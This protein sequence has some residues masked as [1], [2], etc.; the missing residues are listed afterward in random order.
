LRKSNLVAN[1][2]I[3]K[4]HVI[5]CQAIYYITKVKDGVLALPEQ[6]AEGVWGTKS[7]PFLLAEFLPDW[8]QID[9]FVFND[10]TVEGQGQDG[11]IETFVTAAGGKFAF[12]H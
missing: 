7:S 8:F 5:D 2:V 10:G 6:G 1:G 12:N 4:N 3:I 9:H 11:A